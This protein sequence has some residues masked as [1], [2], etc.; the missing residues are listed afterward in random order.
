[1]RFWDTSAL[2]P[3]IID[4]PSTKA[5]RDLVARDADILIWTMT[6]VE[7]LSALRR[8]GRL[9]DGLQDLLPAMRAHAL[10]LVGRCALVT[11]IDGVRRRAERL[12]G[13]HALASADALQL[14][15]ALAA[16]EDRPE[17]LDLVTLDQPLARS[18]RLEGFRVITPN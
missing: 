15:A 3:L 1:M 6:S 4:E 11:D 8:L 10:D 16:S 13:V 18:A 14:A 7:L 9:S 2:V 17:R 12:V 5:A